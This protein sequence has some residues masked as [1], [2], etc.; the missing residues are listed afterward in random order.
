MSLSCHKVQNLFVKRYN[1]PLFFSLSH[2][3]SLPFI[4][5]AIHLTSQPETSTFADLDWGYYD[6]AS[7]ISH[8]PYTSSCPEVTGP[9]PGKTQ[10][11][12]FYT[13]VISMLFMVFMLLF[14]CPWEMDCI[15]IYFSAYSFVYAT[16][17]LFFS[18]FHCEGKKRLGD[19]I[20]R[21][22]SG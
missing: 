7:Y 22:W 10:E 5:L 6:L 1:P 16:I 4:D 19:A 2:Y 11:V 21:P 8:S 9:T 14:A 13:L 17:H 15:Y 3:L 20:Y 12:W 18:L